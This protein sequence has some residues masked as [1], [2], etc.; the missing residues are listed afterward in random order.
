MEPEELRQLLDVVVP[1]RKLE[2]LYIN[3]GN[4]HPI[5][6]KDMVHLENGVVAGEV[7]FIG[8]WTLN[9]IMYFLSQLATF[10]ILNLQG[11]D[12][13]DIDCNVSSRFLLHVIYIQLIISTFVCLCD[14]HNSNLRFITVLLQIKVTSKRKI[15]SPRTFVFRGGM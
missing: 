2:K 14:Q 13:V 7:S 12:I 3:F 1:G 9:N 10:S 15:N 4:P 6:N 5:S 8:Q 11:V